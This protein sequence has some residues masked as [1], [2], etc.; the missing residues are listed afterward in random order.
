M[1]KFSSNRPVKSTLTADQSLV[2]RALIR[3]KYN[4]SS[5]MF[6]YCCTWNYKYDPETY[7]VSYTR[8]H[9]TTVLYVPTKWRRNTMN[10]MM[11]PRPMYCN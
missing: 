5:A 9:I 3:A 7:A 1:T 11:S 8:P 10:T 4:S 6:A 2:K